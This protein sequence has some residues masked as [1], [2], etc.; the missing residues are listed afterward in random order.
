MKT[1]Q[2]LWE[3]SQLLL[4]SRIRIDAPN[5]RLPTNR[6]PRSRLFFLI[7]VIDRLGQ[8]GFQISLEPNNREQKSIERVFTLAR[9]I[10]RIY[11]PATIIGAL[12]HIYR[13]PPASVP[14]E[15]FRRRP[16]GDIHYTPFVPD[17][18]VTNSVSGIHSA[19]V[20]F[21]ALKFPL[22]C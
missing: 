20:R 4:G 6:E 1:G 21:A 9:P 22:P 14:I 2:G 12:N 15:P 11:R 13:N 10:N 18:D 3:S 19:D 8:R 17:I 7:T 16:A 5:F